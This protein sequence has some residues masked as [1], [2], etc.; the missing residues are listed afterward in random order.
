MTATAHTDEYRVG[1]HPALRAWLRVRP[2]SPRPQRI[3]QLQPRKCLTV[4]DAERRVRGQHWSVFRLHAVLAGGRAVIAKYCSRSSGDV[5]VLMYSR[6]LP[7]VG[8]PALEL[9]DVSAEDSTSQWLFL[10]DGGDVEWNV[11]EIE[12]RTSLTEWIAA[13]HARAAA[14]PELA[15]LPRRDARHHHSELSRARHRLE[16]ALRREMLSPTQRRALS[17]LDAQLEAL[18]RDWAEIDDASRALPETLVHRDLAPRNVR[19]DPHEATPSPIVLDW[20]MAGVGP[21]AADLFHVWL[22]DSSELRTR[23]R[24]G[25]HHWCPGLT[26]GD[27]VHMHRVGRVFRIVAAIAWESESLEFPRK[28]EKSVTNLQFYGRRLRD[29]LAAPEGHS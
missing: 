13:L 18:D 15:S 10:S 19:L 11:D 7:R 24:E 12:Q 25:V 8:L 5:E 28:A 21:P 29:A 14:R 4:A 16:A 1:V 27:V 22:A 23:Y 9:L 20:E 26:D 6:V 17:A 3:E 2:D